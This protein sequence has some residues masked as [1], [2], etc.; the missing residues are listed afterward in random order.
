MS[1][2]H[3]LPNYSEAQNYLEGSVWNYLAVP[4]ISP[5]DSTAMAGWVI[6]LRDTKNLKVKA[7]LP[8]TAADT[9]KGLSILLRTA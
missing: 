7:V 4:G 5:A 6:G 3:P 2:R 8:H 1:Y 9:T